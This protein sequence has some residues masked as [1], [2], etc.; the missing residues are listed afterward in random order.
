MT[1]NATTADQMLQQLRADACIVHKFC[2]AC[3]GQLT[4]LLLAFRAFRLQGYVVQ[5]QAAKLGVV[6]GK[7]LAE[8]CRC[9]LSVATLYSWLAA[10][11]EQKCTRATAAYYAGGVQCKQCIQAAATQCIFDL[12]YS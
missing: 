4:L 6:T 3:N 8:H 12:R 5:M 2:R 11:P 7:H 9:V 1:W 10:N